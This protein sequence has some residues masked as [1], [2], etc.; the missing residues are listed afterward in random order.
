MTT[1]MVSMIRNNISTTQEQS[2]ADL[3]VFELQADIC[4]TLANPKRLQIVHLLEEGELP[5]SAIVKTM[6]I[7]K[8]N[9]SQHLSI[10]RQKGLIV[11]RREGTSIYYRLVSTKITDACALMREVLLTL[12]AGQ[13]T[14][15]KS[16]RRNHQV[17]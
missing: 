10:M 4:Q 11:S 1:I 2:R 7:P 5:V 6:A 8:A 14:R 13:E 3:A 15:S 17:S 9:V 12:L 16:I